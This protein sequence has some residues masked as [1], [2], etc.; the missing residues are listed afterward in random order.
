MTLGD[1]WPP[2]DSFA[3][4]AFAV[5]AA[6][7]ARTPDSWELAVGAAITDLFGFLSSRPAQTRSCVGDDQEAA[8]PMALARR[9]AV[10]A[11][12]TTLLRPGFSRG[13]SPPPVVAEAVGGGIYELVRGYAL[14][15]RLEELPAAVPDATV[16]VLSPF[17]G[18]D[19]A[20]EIAEGASVRASG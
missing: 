16:V 15:R 8:S 20:F 9:D 19:G 3:D 1:G 7:Y 14:E 5:A 17:L 2:A 11:R 10:V 13:S 6:A 12:F 4:Q 18:P